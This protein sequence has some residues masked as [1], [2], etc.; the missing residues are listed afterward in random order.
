MKTRLQH[1]NE[2][3]LVAPLLGVP[4]LLNMA[5]AQEYPSKPIRLITS[6]PGSSL[7]LTARV[8]AQGLTTTLGRQ[9]IVDN[10]RI[11][12]VEL[13]AQAPADG[14]TLLAY[15]SP[16]WIAPLLR[17]DLKYDAVKDFAPIT[18]AVSSPNVLVVN[19]RLTAKAVPE[20]V[21]LAKAKP[22]QI[23]YGSS[24]S[25][26]SPHLAAELFNSI[27]SVNLTRIA[28][29]GVAQAVN[30]LIGGQIDVMFPVIATGM[31]HARAGRLR[32]LA[33]TST[34]PWPATPDL[35]T[36]AASGLPGYELTAMHGLLAPAKTPLAII[37]RLNREVV[38]HITQPDIKQKFLVSGS[39]V[40]AGTPQQFASTIVSDMGR[41]AKLI[42]DR[43]IQ[44]E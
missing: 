15:G 16:M 8:I 26:G 18:L 27:A 29:K 11:L 23:N 13:V 9:V 40:V 34:Q 25:G 33:V 41:M 30:D 28:Y 14:Y 35:P 24:V 2:W 44:D 20:L 6:E 36:I 19:S 39:D 37:A 32:A 38:Q 42:R 10:R 3:L 21:A 5:T 31:P 12:A 17:K 7:D 4:G 43:N 22:G 1:A